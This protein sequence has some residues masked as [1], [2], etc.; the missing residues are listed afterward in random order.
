MAAAIFTARWVRRWSPRRTDPN[1]CL[2]HSG[3]DNNQ[4]ASICTLLLLLGSSFLLDSFYHHL[5]A[6]LWLKVS[7]PAPTGKLAF[8]LLHL[9]SL[10]RTPGPTSSGG[11]ASCCIN[12]SSATAGCNRCPPLEGQDL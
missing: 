7:T 3:A 1:V 4:L 8:L 9:T 6:I 10:G 11:S 5:T 12:H 2:A